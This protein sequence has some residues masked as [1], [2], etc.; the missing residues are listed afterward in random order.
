MLAVPASAQ[1]FSIEPGEKVK[2]KSEENYTMLGL[3]L[4]WADFS[5]RGAP[6]TQG[7]RADFTNPIVRIRFK[8][9]EFAFLQ[10][11]VGL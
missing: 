7:G 9:P 8:A 2:T 4:E 10:G 5:Y 11:L 1:M 6:Q 3:S